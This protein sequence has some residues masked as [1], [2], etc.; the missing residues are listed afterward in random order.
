M[1][2]TT[3]DLHKISKP[4]QILAVWFSALVLI[5]G[6]FLNAAEEITTPSWIP[7]TLVVTAI[8][9]VPTFLFLTF[10]LLAKY[11]PQLQDDEHFSD[12]Q[13]RQESYVLSTDENHIQLST[14]E[15]ENKLITSEAG[16][17][18][19]ETNIQFELIPSN[20]KILSTESLLL[21]CIISGLG[22]KEEPALGGVTLVVLWHVKQLKFQDI[23]FGIDLGDKLN[24]ASTY[25]LLEP[26]VF[27][28]SDPDFAAIVFSY[29]S[30][31]KASDLIAMQPSSPCIAKLSFLSLTN[32]PIRVNAGFPYAQNSLLDA[33][34]EPTLNA[35][36][37][38]LFLNK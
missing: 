27:N 30:H 15:I 26:G 14:T 19:K 9:F 1:T 7:A 17:A 5:E 31:I 16:Q 13:K 36:V 33:N 20:K 38:A 10:L 21:D 4:I 24:S 23:Q 22:D 35:S 25:N 37:S 34:K 6:I 12:W 29:H 18:V 28:P 8:I 11:R 3:I 2:K 32:G